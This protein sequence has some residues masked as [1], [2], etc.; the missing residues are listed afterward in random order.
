MCD[1]GNFSILEYI[2][3]GFSRFL[4]PWWHPKLGHI[5]RMLGDRRCRVSPL[6]LESLC[7]FRSGCVCV[8]SRCTRGSR[9][10]AALAGYSR[11]CTPYVGVAGYSS[12]M[13]SNRQKMHDADPDDADAAAGLAS[14]RAPRDTSTVRL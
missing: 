1:C 8:Q 13:W 11:K 12:V 6:S 14:A 5:G 7:I 10:D 3:R 2:E 9:K 4:Y